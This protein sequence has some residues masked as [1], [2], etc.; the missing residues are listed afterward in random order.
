MTYKFHQMKFL[1]IIV[2]LYYPVLNYTNKNVRNLW[3]TCGCNTT[4]R[5]THMS[6]SEWCEILLNGD[7]L[8]RT[9]CFS[10]AM[11]T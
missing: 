5:L 1:H 2:P 8:Y 9:G 7:A 6:L 10:S 11:I 3:H 4:Y